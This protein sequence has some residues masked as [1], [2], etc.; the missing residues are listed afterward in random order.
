MRPNAAEDG[1]DLRDLWRI[2]RRRKWLVLGVCAACLLAAHCYNRTSPVLYESRAALK[3]IPQRDPKK[4]PETIETVMASME[5]D[6]IASAAA[7]RLGIEPEAVR[8]SFSVR[9]IRLSNLIGIDAVGETPE[10][11]VRLAG[12]MMDVFMQWESERNVRRL[13]VDL[14][15]LLGR[16]RAAEQRLA[17][18]EER[19]RAFLEKNQ[20]A[21]RGIQ[22][23]GLLLSLE[24]ERKELLSKWTPN[25]PDVAK[26]DQRIQQTRQS[27]SRLPAQELQF[28]RLSRELKGTEAL[29]ADMVRAETEASAG[30]ESLANNPDLEILSR[31]ELP[32]APS[33]PRRGRN[34][35]LA[36]FLGA[37]LALMLAT[38]LENLDRTL[39]RIDEV[40]SYIGIPV[41]GAAPH[42]EASRSHCIFSAAAGGGFGEAPE[43]KPACL[44][45]CRPCCADIY[46]P[47]RAAIESRMGRPGPKVLVFTST[48]MG[49]GKSLTAVNFCLS[50]AQAGLKTLL[51]DLDL[52]Q[53][54]VHRLLGLEKDPGVVDVLTG[55]RAWKDAILG[56]ADFLL[57]AMDPD[58]VA[59]FS[60]IENFKVMTAW[61]NKAHIVDVL[62]S[63]QLP[64]LLKEMR[65][66]FDLTVI[67]C[68]PLLL[69]VDA[70][71]AAA[72]SD[73]VVLVYRAGRTPRGLLMRAKQMIVEAK[74]NPVGVILNDQRTAQDE[75]YGYYEKYYD[76]YVKEPEEASRAG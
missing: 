34:L 18:L 23:A 10:A 12:V 72:H 61:A 33:Y 54:S 67:D 44:Q 2:A 73:G 29:L 19:K 41:L 68:T 65:N 42:L 52:R 69:F 76:H 22:L 30:L 24:S 15:A 46:H 39:A 45:D 59:A 50:A 75:D 49:E 36:A 6:E 48:Q 64:A 40:E 1:L 53:P 56:T 21:G 31:P 32:K 25:H 3:F 14:D 37:M 63:P 28:E 35:L 7:R 17:G 13:R 62:S 4:M 11:A 38:L 57:G 47:M 66:R 20:T 60:G 74:R 55:G 51:I 9:R 71:L 26:L 8:K 27:L 16:R 5:L 43:G 58:R 70:L